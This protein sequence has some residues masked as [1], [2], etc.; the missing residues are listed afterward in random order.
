M[1]WADC[2]MWE[3]ALVELQEE[4]YEVVM[5]MIRAGTLAALTKLLLASTT[6]YK[7]SLETSIRKSQM[8]SIVLQIA[9][10]HHL[11][12]ETL[13]DRSVTQLEDRDLVRLEIL[14]NSRLLF[15]PVTNACSLL[16]V[17]SWDEETDAVDSM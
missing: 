1:H 17:Q 5:L 11:L 15:L 2:R 6:W 16:H 12:Q 13:Q 14:Q 7:T 9:S 10:D 3:D 4:M 8:S